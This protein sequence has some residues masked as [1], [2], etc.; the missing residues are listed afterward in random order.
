MLRAV[1]FRARCLVSIFS[2][3]I[4]VLHAIRVKNFLPHL[5][6]NNEQLLGFGH[7]FVKSLPVSKLV[8]RTS[9]LRN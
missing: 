5:G 1:R 6:H 4:V 9:P 2:L 8:F 7:Q 3:L